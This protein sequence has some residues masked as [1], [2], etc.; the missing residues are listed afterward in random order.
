[1][2]RIADK[3]LATNA[4]KEFIAQAD[5]YAAKNNLDMWAARVVWIGL[6]F[7][8]LGVKRFAE[9][10]SDYR[11]SKAWA[12]YTRLVETGIFIENDPQEGISWNAGTGP[13]EEDPLRWFDDLTRVAA[14]GPVPEGLPV[15]PG[16]PVLRNGQP[17]N[18]PV[19]R[20]VG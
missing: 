1:M 10:R 16:R 13:W 14:G 9:R 18:S 19:L 12:C 17:A 3:D 4:F 20:L 8:T 15:N 2:P 11:S 7:N 5:R 6:V